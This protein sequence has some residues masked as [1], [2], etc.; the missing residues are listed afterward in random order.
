MDSFEIRIESGIPI[1]RPSTGRNTRKRPNPTAEALGTLQIDES[2]FLPY[3]KDTRARD[4]HR[5][6]ILS[7]I[8]HER[9]RSPGKTFLTRSVVEDGVDGVRVW[10]T[11]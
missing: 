3:P 4:R 1:P 5:N 7:Q 2:F 6:W 8:A 11:E 9:K 10:R